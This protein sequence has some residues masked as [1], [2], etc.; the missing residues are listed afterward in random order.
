MIHFGG[1]RSTIGWHML[2]MLQYLYT[3]TDLP[4]NDAFG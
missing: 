4:E 1:K 3:D 2:K